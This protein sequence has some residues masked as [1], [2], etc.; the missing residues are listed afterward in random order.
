MSTQS[1]SWGP[2]PNAEA[3]EAWDGP[4][5]DRFVQFRHL[6]VDA[7]GPHGEAALTLVRPRAG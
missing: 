3:T 6:V 5:F 1:T 4:L 7:L 2:G